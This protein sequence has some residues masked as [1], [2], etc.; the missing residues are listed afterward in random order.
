MEGIGLE[1]ST[2]TRPDGSVRSGYVVPR[3]GGVLPT[4]M[5]TSLSS[6]SFASPDERR[7]AHMAM[8]DRLA[9]FQ[10]S[11]GFL[12]LT[13]DRRYLDEAVRVVSRR[14]DA[15]VRSIDE[16]LID[17]MR[18]IAISRNAEW[19]RLLLADNEQGERGW[20]ILGQVV[21]QALPEVTEKLLA[22]EGLITLE[23]VGLLARYG[24]IDVLATLRDRLTRGTEPA[25]LAGLVL[26]V[27]GSDPHA[28][29]SID[30]EAIPVI[31]ANQWGHIPST[32]LR[33]FD[34][35]EAA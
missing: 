30:G 6:T 19:S 34:T 20:T 7:A 17:Q 11:G 1:W 25:V 22:R 33:S 18:A 15:P 24:R 21:G 29:P 16:M 32:W 14:L 28:R 9:S 13:V 26:V 31:T 5:I 35:T 4:T 27:P 10:R 12:A 2:F 23:G 3:R 8:N